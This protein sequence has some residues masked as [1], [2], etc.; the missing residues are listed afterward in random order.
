MVKYILRGIAATML[1]F[2]C[3]AMPFAQN[4]SRSIIGTNGGTISSSAGTFNFTIGE[5]VIPSI[6]G[7]VFLLTQG[8]QQPGEQIES[9][10]FT[11][12]LCPGTQVEI[13]FEAFDI[14]AGNTFKAELSDASGNFSSPL[15]IGTLAGN[16]S[17]TII[18]TIPLNIAPGTGYRIRIVAS[19]PATV[20]LSNPL[21]LE[22]R[23]PTY[24]AIAFD[25]ILMKNNI[26]YSG[27][28]GLVNASKKVKLDGTNITGATTFVRAPELQ[29]I[30]GAVVTTFYPE[31]VLLSALIPFQSFSGSCLNFPSV[32]V[33]GTSTLSLSGYNHI[34]IEKNATVYFSGNATIN[35]E[36]LDIMEGAKV[37]FQQNTNLR[38]KE[39]IDFGKSAVVNNN[40][41][42]VNIFSPK[43]VKIQ[44][45]NNIKAN[46]ICLGLIIL[47]AAPNINPTNIT[48]LFIASK[49][50]SKDNV[51]WY[52]GNEDCGSPFMYVGI[53]PLSAVEAIAAPDQQSISIYP[54]P[55]SNQ[56][57]LKI[58]GNLPDEKFEIVVRDMNGRIVWNEAAQ[59][60]FLDGF[61]VNSSRFSAG[62]YFVQVHSNSL[63]LAPVRLAIIR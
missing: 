29:K 61:R 33:T 62:Y 42:T 9:G 49:I 43:N 63:N 10:N 7:G 50:N 3:T 1:L 58:K 21:N 23:P 17:G 57:M 14:G 27:G 44:Q 22:I 45:G 2:G 30:Q 39:D 56:F 11:P 26:V 31:Q 19:S 16:S 35:V 54:N 6:T 46:I 37:Y 47:D 36:R 59:G 53:E 41:Y 52:N 40:G 18:V 4:I 48:G 38:I 25:D 13:P 12:Y 8:F 15:V 20:S 51:R 55:A 24:T 5:T 60:R 32:T 28:V 34:K